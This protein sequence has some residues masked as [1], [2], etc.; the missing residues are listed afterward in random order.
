MIKTVISFNANQLISMSKQ[1]SDRYK[2]DV[3]TIHK[4][5]YSLFPKELNAK[6]SF[7]KELIKN[8][9]QFIIIQSDKKPILPNFIMKSQVQSYAY[10]DDFFENKEF[11]FVIDINS[12]KRRASTGKYCP[13][14][15]EEI[16]NWIVNKFA[17]NNL[18]VTDIN[19]IS[20]KVE[21]FFV[22]NKNKVTVYHSK[23]IGK[24][25]TSDKESIKNAMINGIGR[26]KTYGF[27]MLILN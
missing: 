25:K 26:E 5:V 14:K 22:K 6:F 8:G 3:Y 7:N 24:V 10:S 19:L 11:K 4:F 12:S 27:G 20:Q 21:T 13:I 1:V 18:Q 15:P 23:I 2:P 9:K 17:Q 16:N